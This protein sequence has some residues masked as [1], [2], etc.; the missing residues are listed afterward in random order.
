MHVALYCVCL[1]VRDSHVQETSAL[2]LLKSVVRIRRENFKGK[3]RSVWNLT[4]QKTL[5]II[6]LSLCGKSSVS[7]R[8]ILIYKHC[9]MEGLEKGGKKTGCLGTSIV[10]SS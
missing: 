3:G 7:Y 6:Q 8:K 1:T 4:A 10:C 2:D 5:S 9:R